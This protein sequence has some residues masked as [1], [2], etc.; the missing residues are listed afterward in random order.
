MRRGG[1]AASGSGAGAVSTLATGASGA[2]SKQCAR[3]PALIGGVASQPSRAMGIVSGAKG[4]AKEKAKA[5]AKATGKRASAPPTVAPDLAEVANTLM[6][7][8]KDLSE[9]MGRLEQSSAERRTDSSFTNPP[10][11]ASIPVDLW[12][13]V[14]G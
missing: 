3:P 1:T 9:R 13:L 14:L 10:G 12:Y 7:G 8:V 11:L 5:K 2:L 4:R 6:Q